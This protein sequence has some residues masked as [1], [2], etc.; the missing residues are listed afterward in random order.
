M[1]FCHKIHKIFMINALFPRN[2]VVS[3]YALFPP[4]FLSWKVVSAIF[5]AFW[6]Y[7]DDVLSVLMYIVEH[8]ATVWDFHLQHIIGTQSLQHDQCNNQT[9]FLENVYAEFCA[10]T[11]LHATLRCL[12]EQSKKE[13]LWSAPFL[14]CLLALM[15][16]KVNLRSPVCEQSSVQQRRPSISGCSSTSR[17]QVG[18]MCLIKVALK[19]ITCPNKMFALKINETRPKY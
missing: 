8:R 4:I 2:F 9:K 16:L 10:P 17:P 3:M 15:I 14:I 18:C 12:A 5:S 1:L 6:M 7:G 19:S 11:Q 13:Y